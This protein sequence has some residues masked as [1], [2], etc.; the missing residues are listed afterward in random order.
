MKQWRVSDRDTLAIPIEEKLGYHEWKLPRDI[1][2][3]EQCRIMST[4]CPLETKESAFTVFQAKA[5]QIPHPHTDMAVE[6][7]LVASY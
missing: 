3:G 1:I 7:K 6:K 2:V 4:A 5:T